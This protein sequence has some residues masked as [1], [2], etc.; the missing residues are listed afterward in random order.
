MHLR[1]LPNALTIFRLVLVPILLMTPLL[2]DNWSSWAA[3]AVLVCAGM[4]D[5]LDGAL[6]RRL[7]VISEIGRMLDPIADKLMIASA[8]LLLLWQGSAPLVPAIVI[9]ARELLVSGLREYLA[10][11]GQKLEVSLLAKWKTT[12]QFVALAVLMTAGA[13][14]V[15]DLRGFSLEIIGVGLFWAAGLLTLITGYK[16]WVEAYSFAVDQHSETPS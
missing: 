10:L 4:T 8:I 5:Y 3:L 13:P 15:P 12:L 16:Y 6:A 14:N 7:N 11:A 2:P 1:N 9:I